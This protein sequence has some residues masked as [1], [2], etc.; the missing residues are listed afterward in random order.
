VAAS[1]LP[2]AATP[3]HSDA[4]VLDADGTVE[5]PSYAE[6]GSSKHRG[7]VLAIT[8]AVGLRRSTVVE[9]Q[10][11][12]ESL[13]TPDLTAVIVGCNAMLIDDR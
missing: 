5:V 9:F 2:R 1:R 11:P 10:Q 13:A 7:A 3:D 12:T 6:I 4:V 8:N